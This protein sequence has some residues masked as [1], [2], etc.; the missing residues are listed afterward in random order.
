MHTHTHTH[1]HTHMHKH[2]RTHTHTHMHTHTHTHTHAR[3]H[4]HTHRVQFCF[5]LQD[6]QVTWNTTEPDFTPCFQKT[7]L[8]WIPVAFL[9]LLA[10][11]K[12]YSHCHLKDRAIKWNWLNC[13]K[14]VTET[15]CGLIYHY[16]RTVCRHKSYTR[17]K[18]F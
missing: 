10:P 12:L 11:L 17:G 6:D 8:S 9:L 7:V 3:V 1:T 16:N 5:G 13:S 14:M 2:T 4:T 18:C 15:L